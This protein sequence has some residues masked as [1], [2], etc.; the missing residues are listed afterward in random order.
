MK[1]LR[2]AM[3]DLIQGIYQLIYWFP[4]IFKNKDWD[5]T[6]TEIIL[7]HQL[8]LQYKRFSDPSVTYVNWE[9][10]SAAKQL[11]A[12]KICIILLERLST[13][14]YYQCDYKDKTAT[15]LFI[16]EEQRR[17]LLYHLM[18]KYSTGWWD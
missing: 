11:K 9:E 5:F 7:L 8:K 17:K 13:D 10:E 2:I 18:E 3:K 15:M 12:L 6:Y 14:W 4:V 16:V 1:K